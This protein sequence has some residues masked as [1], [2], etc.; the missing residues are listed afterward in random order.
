L[1]L[2]I[3]IEESSQ[4]EFSLHKLSKQEEEEGE[5]VF[6]AAFVSNLPFYVSFYEEHSDRRDYQSVNLRRP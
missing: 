4:T 1:K 2:E 6:A 5:G 3:N